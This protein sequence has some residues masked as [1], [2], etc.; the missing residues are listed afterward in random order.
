MCVCV[1][2]REVSKSEPAEMLQRTTWSFRSDV[3]S[4]QSCGEAFAPTRSAF[5]SVLVSEDCGYAIVHQ[6]RS[7][8]QVLLL[9]CARQLICAFSTVILRQSRLL[10][11]I[12]TGTP[13]TYRVE[14]WLPTKCCFYFPFVKLMFAFAL[15]CICSC[16]FLISFIY[17]CFY[18]LSSFFFSSTVGKYCMYPWQRVCECAYAC[19]IRVC[20]V[21]ARSLLSETQCGNY[22]SLPLG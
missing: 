17:F 4:H 21:C 11:S 1:L 15:F 10:K 12:S 18:R 2:R 3:I 8:Q 14:R 5:L 16:Y 13:R 9:M 6:R 20:V 22:R 7:I 19:S